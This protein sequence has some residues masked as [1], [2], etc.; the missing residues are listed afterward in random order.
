MLPFKYGNLTFV[1]APLSEVSESAHAQPLL[2]HYH[3]VT[4]LLQVTE[5]I[6]SLR[7]FSDAFIVEYLLFC[8]TLPS[9]RIKKKIKTSNLVQ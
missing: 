8:H 6:L 1:G 3:S 9:S 4:V 2:P 5:K 7:F